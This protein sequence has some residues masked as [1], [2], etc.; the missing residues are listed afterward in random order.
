MIFK[1]V[2]ELM[3]FQWFA[4]EQWTKLKERRNVFNQ[5][6]L[7]AHFLFTYIFIIPVYICMT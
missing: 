1:I 7:D 3:N 2:E 6:K 5:Y 4:I